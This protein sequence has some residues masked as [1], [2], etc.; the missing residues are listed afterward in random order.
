MSYMTYAKSSECLFN[1]AMRRGVWQ[2]L[3][4][5]LQRQPVGLVHF[6]QV[7]PSINLGQQYDTGIR[8][9]PVH[10]IVGSLG[11]VTEF[12]RDFMPINPCVENKW[13]HILRL[14]STG[15]DLPPIEVYK[16]NGGYYVIDGNHRVSVSRFLGMDY[17]DA[18]VIEIVG[19]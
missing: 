19:K 4:R 3:L 6:D 11:R 7:R 18:H 8:P 12:D 13:R 5:R 1:R 9:I 2:R 15:I 10:D 14:K 16:L 17:I